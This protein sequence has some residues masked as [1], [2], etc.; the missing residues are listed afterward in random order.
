MSSRATLVDGQMRLDVPPGV[1]WG[2]AELADLCGS[3]VSELLAELAAD[4]DI[5]AMKRRVALRRAQV[6]TAEQRLVDIANRYRDGVTA[7]DEFLA[8]LE[9]VLPRP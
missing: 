1:W 7:D 9:D 3:T 4:A 6:A 5:D 8:Y 2:L